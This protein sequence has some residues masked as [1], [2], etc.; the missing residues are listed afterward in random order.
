ML[1]QPSLELPQHHTAGWNNKR[2]MLKTNSQAAIEVPEITPQDQHLP[3]GSHRQSRTTWH[4]LP[5]PYPGLFYV[6]V[7]SVENRGLLIWRRA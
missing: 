4:C 5:D 6:I 1:Q 2:M 3:H 7:D